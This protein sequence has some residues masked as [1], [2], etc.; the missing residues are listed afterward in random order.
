MNE[1]VF[2]SLV[3]HYGFQGY[4]YALSVAGSDQENIHI[5][6]GDQINLVVELE[7]H[8]NE[9]IPVGSTAIADKLSSKILQAISPVTI[10]GLEVGVPDL[11]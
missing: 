5:R 9:E 10:G 7:G 6:S 11:T 2:H 4:G 3:L 8:R 1:Y